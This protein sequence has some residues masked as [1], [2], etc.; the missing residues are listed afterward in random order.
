[1][2]NVYVFALVE[3]P[4]A[5]T[6]TAASR[7]LRIAGHRIEF[8]A[9]GGIYA[10]VERAKAQPALSEE[11]L[12]DQHRVVVEL[13]RRCDAILPARFGGWIESGD[14]EGLVEARAPIL[15]RA[16]DTV[17]NKEQMT[18]RIFTNDERPAAPLPA[19]STGTAYLEALKAAKAPKMT[20]LAASIRTAVQ[21]L[22][23]GEHIDAG[24]GRLQVALHHLVDR[25]RST[26]YEARVAEV[27]A[28]LRPA[29]SVAVSGPWP[30]FA[31]AP[32][33]WQ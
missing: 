23:G 1:M 4:P 2:S 25:G 13:G 7:P 19:G 17:R 22:A 15:Q 24:R 5:S 27:V 31:F 32:D 16:L 12:R 9:V 10:A 21:P 30:P 14:L 8:V 20:P 3:R 11:S 28:R 33:L 29:A 6:G 26:D 18:V